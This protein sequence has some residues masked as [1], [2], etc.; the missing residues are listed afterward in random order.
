MTLPA[1]EAVDSTSGVAQV[2]DAPRARRRPGHAV[3]FEIRRQAKAPAAA[4][5]HAEVSLPLERVREALS[6]SDRGTA[7]LV[8]D[9]ALVRAK[10]QRFAA[11]LPRV[12]PHFAVKAN[13]HADVLRALMA[14]GTGFEI[15]SPAELDLLLSLGARPED[16]L[17]SNPIRGRHQIEYAARRGVRWFVVDCAQEL[18]KFVGLDGQARLYVRIEAPNDGSDWP[19]TG[20][21]GVAMDEVATVIAEAAR[22]G[23]RIE[24]VTFHVGSQCRNPNNWRV[25]IQRARRVF[26]L[27]TA[28]GMRPSLL[29]LGGGFPVQLTKPIPSI[30]AIGA[31]VGQE[32]NAFDRDIRIVAEPGRYLVADAGCFVAHVIGTATRS[33][34]RWM[35]WDA[36]VFG[37]L[38]EMTDGLRFDLQTDCSGPLVPWHVAGPTCDSVDVCLRDEL[39]PADLVAGDR[40]YVTNAGA[41]TT[42][43]ASHF[44]GFPLPEVI[45][46]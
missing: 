38:V 20:K 2:P 22:L 6:G 3:R 29:D 23:L 26:D 7:A 10:A 21:F 11:A 35:Y 42:A 24:G 46:L 14:E 44:N 36:G 15:A 43:Y 8:L 33:G 1:F 17:Y 16:I 31:V 9:T 18:A 39:L 34:R 45:V 27:L 41:Y 5:A 32:L 40:V 30:E 28:A 19:L 13:P 12:R 37:G 25:G 4:P